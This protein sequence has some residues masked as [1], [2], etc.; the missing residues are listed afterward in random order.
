MESVGS[1]GSDP[2]VEVDTYRAIIRGWRW[3]LV[4]SGSFLPHVGRVCSY[5]CESHLLFVIHIIDSE[6]ALVNVVIE[7]RIRGRKEFLCVERQR[8]V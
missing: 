7:T 3:L 6:A 5:V 2:R 1:T 8:V 4:D